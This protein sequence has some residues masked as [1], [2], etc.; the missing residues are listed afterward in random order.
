MTGTRISWPCRLKIGAKTKKGK[1]TKKNYD[2]YFKI[3]RFVF[4]LDPHVRIFGKNSDVMNAK[5]RILTS[6][7]SRVSKISENIP[8][9]IVI[10]LISFKI[11]L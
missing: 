6:L 8:N 11:G 7:D 5:E 1:N 2:K 3:L 9:E 10:Y 4:L